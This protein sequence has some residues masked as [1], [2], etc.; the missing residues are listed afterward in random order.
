MKGRKV[1]LMKEM[2]L[3]QYKEEV[4]KEL[5]KFYQNEEIVNKEMELCKQ[6]IET[7]RTFMTPAGMAEVIEM[8]L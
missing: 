8:G 7:D 3:Q 1:T 5:M 2:T 4:K 6:Q